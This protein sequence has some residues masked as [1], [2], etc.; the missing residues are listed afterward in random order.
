[1]KTPELITRFQEIDE[2]LKLI[3][4]AKINDPALQSF[5]S[6]FAVV[7]ISGVYEECIEKLF[8]LRASKT[9]DK[10]LISYI[11]KSVDKG[12]RNPNYDKILE[13]LGYF[14]EDYKK[15]FKSRVPEQGK[16]AINSIVTNK[17]NIAHGKQSNVTIAD[18]ISYHLNAKVIFDK[19][20][21]I[22]L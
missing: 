3:S 14:G 5:L 20:E 16:Q 4:S 15:S 21:L 13:F 11:E 19:L 6:G 1:M 17:N 12:F 10:H 9:K 18:I 2:M 7:Y 22:L 8:V